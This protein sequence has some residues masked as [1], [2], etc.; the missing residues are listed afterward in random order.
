ME[1]PDTADWVRCRREGNKPMSDDASDS[2]NAALKLRKRAL[3][4]WD[5][6]GG[7]ELDGPQAASVAVEAEAPMPDNGAAEIASLHVRV[8]ALENLLITL[9]ATASD[10]QIELAGEMAA[11]IAP[12]PGFTHHALTT[13]AAAHMNDLVKRATHFRVEE[14]S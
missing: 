2:A 6:E 9:L 4:R 7:A 14:P 8:I 11:Y 10:R 12:R 1:S 3:A 13:R 5:N